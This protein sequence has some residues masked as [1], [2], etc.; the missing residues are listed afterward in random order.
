MRE[1]RNKENIIIMNHEKYYQHFLQ[2][3]INP[4]QLK[5]YDIKKYINFSSNDYLGLTKHPLLI[6][7]SQH[8]A[9]E[10]GVGAASSRLVTGNLSLYD[11]IEK[12]LAAAIGKPAALI[13]AS[14]YQANMSVLE[15]LLD[16]HVLGHEPLIFCDRLCHA[17]L[18]TVTQYVTK[19]QRFRHN[20]LHHL[21][22]LLEKYKDDSRAKFILVESV[23]SMDG[24]QADLKNIIALAKKYHAFLYVDDAHAVG[25]YGPAGFVK[26]AEYADDIDIIMG[27]FSKALGSF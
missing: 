4:R 16:D 25:V 26:A 1:R 14:G 23:Y 7:R 10:F 12:K 3:N 8:Y 18:L 17:S 27:T 9:K 11:T 24:D 13:L 2:E 21:Q 5:S 22:E 15:A 20:D 6:E 19:L